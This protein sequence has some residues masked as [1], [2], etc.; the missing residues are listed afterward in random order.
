MHFYVEADG[1]SEDSSMCFECQDSREAFGNPNL[2]EY[3]KAKQAFSFCVSTVLSSLPD[4]SADASVASVEVKKVIMTL[5]AAATFKEYY[6]RLTT[7]AGGDSNIEGYNAAMDHEASQSDAVKAF[8]NINGSFF[9]A[10][11]DKKLRIIHG[12][13]NLGNTMSRPESKIGGH[14]GMNGVAFVGHV[15]FVEALTISTFDT[16]TGDEL[17]S[18][19]TLAA[20]RALQP[21]VSPEIFEGPRVFFPAPFVQRAVFQSGSSCPMELI[22]KVRDA[23]AEYIIAWGLSG[24]ALEV[25]DAHIYLLEQFCWATH[26]GKLTTTGAI[27]APDADDDELIDF[28][29]RYHARRILGIPPEGTTTTTLGAAPTGGVGGEGGHIGNLTLLTQTLSRVL[30]EQGSSAEI[31]EK[32]HQ[33][34]VDKEVDKKDK[35]ERW[36]PD[37]R[38]VV[39]FAAST[40]GVLPGLGIP[41]S[42]KR[43]INADTIGNA[44][45]ELNGQMRSLGNE[46][47]EWD[48]TFTNTL[49]N[50]MFLYT[51]T[52]TPSGFSIFLL[53]VKNPTEVQAQDARGMRLH[54]LETG[55]DNNKSVMELIESNKHPIKLPTT[56]EDL[57]IIL[58]GFG[59][60]AAICF[61]KDSTLPVSL[62][63]LARDL[64][65]NK[66]LLKGKI[67][68][69]PTLITKLLYTV[70]LRTQLWMSYLHRAGDRDEVNDEAVEFTSVMTDILLEQ[71]QV[72]LPATFTHPKNTKENERKKD[73]EPK[74]KKQK[75]TPLGEIEVDRIEKNPNIPAEFQLQQGESYKKVFARRCVEDRPKWNDHSSMCPRWW[76]IGVC[77]GDCRN[78]ESHVPESELPASKKSEFVEFLEKARRG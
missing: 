51:K 6:S 77:Y 8:N 10:G 78:V 42:Y 12:L 69:D 62:L 52:D 5:A 35:S 28:S 71:F 1:R 47:V 33:F 59:G 75:G 29:K 19:L 44:D 31:L 63:N 46:E 60:L 39:R 15:D 76:I 18:C 3:S 49:R 20:L 37:T 72:N 41:S 27:F 64:S 65:L 54:I 55:K 14:T 30:E 11:Q 36:H 53:R 73:G 40:D 21:G 16:P 57:L 38:R 13:T 45:V 7:S 43:I 4:N 23:Y 58:K 50:G 34:S 70:D 66:L 9:Y 17:G 61:G 74:R 25:A 67:M 24:D 56:I 32:M 22:F 2:R 48:V 26:N 68:N